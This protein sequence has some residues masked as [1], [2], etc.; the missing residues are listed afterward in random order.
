MSKGM[1][2]GMFDFNRDGHMSPFESAAECMFFHEVILADE[3][4]KESIENV[5][6]DSADFDEFDF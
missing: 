6:L 1:F 2:D 3:N 4:K 5:D